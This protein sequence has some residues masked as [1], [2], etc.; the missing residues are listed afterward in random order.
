MYAIRSY[1]V[2]EDAQHFHACCRD[3]LSP[4]GAE[5]HPRF[6]RWC[7]EYFFLK[8]R[9]EPRGIGGIFF[10]DLNDPDFETCFV[11]VITSYSI[12]YTKL[13]DPKPRSPRAW[14]MPSRPPV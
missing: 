1:Y 4:F 7:D 11:L 10:D 5:Y 12:H 14:S 8:H 13:Y 2:V 9:N 6:K 3:A